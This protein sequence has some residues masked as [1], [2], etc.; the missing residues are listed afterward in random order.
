MA[1]IQPARYDEKCW[2]ATLLWMNAIGRYDELARALLAHDAPVRLV[3]IDGCGGAGKTTFATRLAAA[4]NDAP[5]VHTDDFAS[6]DVP[7]EWWPRLLDGVIEPLLAGRAATYLAYDWVRRAPG[8]T[9]TIDPAPLVVIEGVGACRRVWRDRLVASIWIDTPR[10]ERHRRGLARDGAELAEFWQEWI[11]AE[12]AY[13]A[14]EDPNEAADLVID[15]APAM[16]YDEDSEFVIARRKGA[17][18]WA[19]PQHEPG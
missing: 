9:V 8:P 3:G 18:G 7:I 19:P 17:A 16:S 15:G 12:D 14:A 1:P 6:H 4:A 11:V 2:F 10:E 5:V 13:V